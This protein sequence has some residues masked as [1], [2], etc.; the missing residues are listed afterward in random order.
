MAAL[1]HCFM[2]CERGEGAR[3]CLWL[4]ILV[5]FGCVPDVP[6]RNLFW[7]RVC[8]PGSLCCCLVACRGG[9]MLGRSESSASHIS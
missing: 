9:S 7:G 3:D 2:C 5:R 1:C 8:T 6:V 4:V